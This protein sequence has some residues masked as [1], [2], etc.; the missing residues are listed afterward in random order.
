[1]V[2]DEVRE[3]EPGPDGLTSQIG[4]GL[5]DLGSILRMEVNRQE[6]QGS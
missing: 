3:Q 4:F 1:M 5:E 2:E 6:T